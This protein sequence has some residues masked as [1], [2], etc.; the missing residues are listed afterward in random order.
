VTGVLSR[1]HVLEPVVSPLVG[2]SLKGSFDVERW[3][4]RLENK[5]GAIKQ[6]SLVSHC[7]AA[8]L[9]LRFERQCGKKSAAAFG[10]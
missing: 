1:E 4:Q 7:S 5:W 10:S 6:S 8:P 3:Q 9:A 2:K